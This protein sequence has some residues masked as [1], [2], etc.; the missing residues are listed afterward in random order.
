MS[1]SEQ[2]SFHGQAFDRD[3]SFRSLPFNTSRRKKISSTLFANVHREIRSQSGLCETIL[4]VNRQTRGR[5][6]NI[7]SDELN[8]GHGAH[9]DQQH[10]ED[11]RRHDDP[12]GVQQPADK[13]VERLELDQQA[14]G[15]KQTWAVFNGP[16]DS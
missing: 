10:H 2:S 9:V 13:Q 6:P 16:V 11:E 14:Y 8:D 1:C 12:E 4:R 3:W 5:Q 15:S 7:C